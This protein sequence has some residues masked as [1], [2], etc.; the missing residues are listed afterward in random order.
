MVI[1]SYDTFENDLEIDSTVEQ[2]KSK[3]LD[4]VSQPDLW[5]TP[6]KKSNSQRE[7]ELV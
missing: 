5:N 4:Y 2:N 7:P 6:I 1:R 3:I